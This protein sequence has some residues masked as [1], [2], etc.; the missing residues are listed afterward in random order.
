MVI[1]HPNK[2]Q[3]LPLNDLS[4]YL[5]DGIYNLISIEES[6]KVDYFLKSFENYRDLNKLKITNTKFYEGLPFSIST[7]PWLERQKDVKFISKIIEG[8]TNLKILDVGAWNGWLSNYLTKKSHR[9]VA[10]DLFTDSYD[11]LGA[12]K[13]YK[14][15]YIS[16]QVYPDEIFRIKDAFDLIIFNR[17]WAFFQNPQKVFE[18]AKRIL[19]PNGTILFTGLAFYQNPIIAKKQLEKTNKNFKKSYGIPLLYKNSKGYLTLKDKLFFE[20]NNALLFLDN[21]IK[22]FVKL[23]FPKK[24]KIYY[25]T[26]TK[27]I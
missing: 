27:D 18:D 12:H 22:N 8:K 23:L 3:Y 17:N 11:G 20:K 25:A 10:L 14:S 15:K 13:H 6:E 19:S 21:P 24:P 2:N 26:Y 5:I 1:L 7:S 16:I 9:L 4:E